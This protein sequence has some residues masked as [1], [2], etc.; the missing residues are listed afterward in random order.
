MARSR[1][2]ATPENSYF[3][4]CW[5]VT[6]GEERDIE[7]T[8]ILSFHAELRCVIVAG[9]DVCLTLLSADQAAMFLWSQ[10]MAEGA[11][12]TQI[13]IELY[14][15][16]PGWKELS[17]D[18]RQVFANTVAN[19]VKGLAQHGVDVIAWGMNDQATAYRAPYDFYCVYKVPS[20]EFQ[21]SFDAAV[22]ASGWYNY[23]EQVCVS[24]KALTPEELLS[25]N[26]AL[27]TPGE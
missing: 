27:S 16:R 10:P 6:D 23:F 5:P 18:D 11:E 3:S 22:E 24:G 1:A 12:M 2:R 19:E 26:V 4:P 9:I 25:A 7:F 8:H 13:F 14:N 17:A 15:Y 20:A 21:R